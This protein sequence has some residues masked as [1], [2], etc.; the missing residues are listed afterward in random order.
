MLL[1]FLISSI[2]V[3]ILVILVIPSKN[4]IFLKFFS[5]LLSLFIFLFSFYLWLGFD[6]LESNFQYTYYFNWSEIYNIT[7]SLGVDGISIFFVILTS[8]LVPICFLSSWGSINFRIK[9]FIVILLFTEFFLINI[10]CVTDL[11]F[12]YIFFESVLIPV[13]LLIGIWGSR[14]RKIHAAYQFFL[15]TLVGSLIMLIG[16]IFIYAHLGSTD[17]QYLF[18]V[19]FSKQRQLLLWF[20][21]FMSLFVK[22]PMFPV[23][24]W[25]PEAHVEAP[26]VGSVLLAGV[27]LKLGAYGFLRFS[28]P[29]FPH[30]SLF[31]IPFI[32]MLSFFAIIYGALTTI[33]QIDLKKI[34]AYSS[35][36]HMGYTTLGIFSFTYQGIQGSLLLML[37][38]GF[39]SSALFLCIGVMYDRYKTRIIQYY[40]AITIFMPLFS[41]IF[42][43]FT[44]ANIGLP[45]TINFVSELLVL[46]GISTKNY[47]LTILASFAIVLGA[48]YSIWLY[49]RIAFGKFLL[50]VSGNSYQFLYF[51]C[52]INKRE[53]FMFVPLIFFTIL[54]GFYPTLFFSTMEFSISKLLIN[55]I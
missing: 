51:F 48:V 24:I 9:E 38:H 42:L 15:Y 28:I 8:L 35:I 22:I 53:F 40:S 41:S 29:L 20:S 45:G 17:I 2:F 36:V 5:L 43:F 7:Y 26:T 3:G 13:F 31:F 37:G 23:H 52:D 30:A 6:L 49:N 12:F 4:I 32:Y 46:F 11:L 55:N 50:Q 10:F 18:T 39:I 19:T 54:L 1:F 16:V 34:V 44:L 21:F 14:Q 25:L 33:N 47:F 27:L